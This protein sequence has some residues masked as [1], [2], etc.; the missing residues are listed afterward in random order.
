MPA[1]YTGELPLQ[2]G[3]Q[4]SLDLADMAATHGQWRQAGLESYLPAAVVFLFQ[5]V[6]VRDCDQRVAVYT[7]ETLAKLGFKILQRFIEQRLAACVVRSH[8]FLVGLE[9]VDVLDPDHL[10]RAAAL[11]TDLGARQRA[12]YRRQLHATD[13]RRVGQRLLQ[14]LATHGLQQVTDRLGLESLDRI[15]V[16]GRGEDDRRLAARGWPGDAATCSPSRP[17]MRM[18]SSMMSGCSSLASCRASAP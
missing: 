4:P 12:G 2:T 3:P 14:A 5:A 7:Q 11:G 6:H 16:V 1:D 18:S 9:A 17:G 13:A 15:F 10:Q 8:V